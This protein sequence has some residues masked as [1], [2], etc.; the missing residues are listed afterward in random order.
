[1]RRKLTIGDLKRPGMC[2]GFLVR[3]DRHCSELA[4]RAVTERDID[5]VSPDRDRKPIGDLEFPNPRDNRTLLNDL[6]EHRGGRQRSFIRKKNQLSVS[7]A[8]ST[9]LNGAPR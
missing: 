8:S 1:V 5:A 7:E 4:D 9:T 6:I 3:R 2:I